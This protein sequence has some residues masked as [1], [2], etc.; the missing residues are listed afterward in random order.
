MSIPKWVYNILISL[1]GDVQLNPGPKN[2]SDVNF[3]I[4]YWNLNSISAHNYA[5]VFLL[6]AYIAVYKF[7]ITCISETYLDTS[8]ISDDGNLEV[9]GYNLIRSDHPSNSKRGGVCI[10]YNHPIVS[11]VVFAFIITIQ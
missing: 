9:L 2:K 3:S 11:V 8:I 7:D 5:K 10:Y 1:S 4:C 6:K